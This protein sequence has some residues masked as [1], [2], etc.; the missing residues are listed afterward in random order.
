M[1]DG[2]ILDFREL[3]LVKISGDKLCSYMSINWF[4]KRY[5]TNQIFHTA[6]FVYIL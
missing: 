6:A 5:E 4:D 1:W 3:F 2:V